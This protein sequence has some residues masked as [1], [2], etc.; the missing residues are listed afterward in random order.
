LDFIHEER[1]PIHEPETFKRRPAGEFTGVGESKKGF[2]ISRN[3]F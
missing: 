2:F 1:Q 3:F